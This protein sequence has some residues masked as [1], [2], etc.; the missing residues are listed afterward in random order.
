MPNIKCEKCVLYLEELCK[1]NNDINSFKI[2]LKER[3]KFFGGIPYTITPG[4]RHNE[5]INISKCDGVLYYKPFDKNP[6]NKT[7]QISMNK[8]NTIIN[9]KEM[10]NERDISNSNNIQQNINTNELCKKHKNYYS[11]IFIVLIFLIIIIKF[12]FIK[13]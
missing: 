4:I 11:I 12:V 7:F 13:K 8:L 6:K 3:I 9:E 10:L 5:I 2:L 1:D